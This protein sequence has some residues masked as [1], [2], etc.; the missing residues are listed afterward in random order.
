[1]IYSMIY[2]TLYSMISLATWLALSHVEKLGTCFSEEFQTFHNCKL[3]VLQGYYDLLKLDLTSKDDV[4]K[5]V[6]LFHSLVIQ[7]I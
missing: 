7:F 2:S 4:L 5:L 6:H 1:M 3:A